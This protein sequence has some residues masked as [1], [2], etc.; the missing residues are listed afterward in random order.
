MAPTRCAS[1]RRGR[2][3]APRSLLA[4]TVT[5]ELDKNAAA[6]RIAQRCSQGL[7]MFNAAT[8]QL[9]LPAGPG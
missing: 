1:A 8:D 7:Y 9:R 5:S 3:A 2:S 4:T 6:G